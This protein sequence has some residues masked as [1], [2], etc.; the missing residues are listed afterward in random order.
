[1]VRG[2]KFSQRVDL[3]GD[4]AA[5]GVQ[6][7]DIQFAVR[8]HR[9]VATEKTP[10]ESADTKAQTQRGK[11]PNFPLVVD[12]RA[13]PASSLESHTNYFVIQRRP[14]F[15]CCTPVKD[16]TSPDGLVIPW[17]VVVE[18]VDATLVADIWNTVAERYLEAV[19]EIRNDRKVSLF[20][21]LT[22][23]GD[24]KDDENQTLKGDDRSDLVQ[25]HAT[26]AHACYR[27]SLADFYPSGQDKLPDERRIPSA[28]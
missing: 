27:L 6:S 25:R 7:Y 10:E 28:R 19:R 26:Y 21:R 1:M 16:R 11:Q 9:E 13:D 23:K 12:F 17:L 3:V 20:P 4:S 22:V 2:P 24:T 8:A 15:W 18:D 5:E 14:P